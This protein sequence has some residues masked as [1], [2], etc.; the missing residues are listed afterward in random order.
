MNAAR[1]V[2]LDNEAVQA[3]ADPAH[4]K[5]RRVLAAVQA[6]ASRNLRHAGSISLVVPT[7]VQVEAGWGRQQPRHAALNRL[8][9]SRPGLDG[10]TA[11]N[12]AEVVSSTGVTPADAHITVTLKATTAPHAVI[13]SNEPDIRRGANH[14]GISVVI[15]RV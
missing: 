5:H 11:D 15:V 3:L 7:T 6:T 2:I 9:I 10:R 14:V 13:T 12:A 1:T 8:R 4:H